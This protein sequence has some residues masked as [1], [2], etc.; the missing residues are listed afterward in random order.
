M[1]FFHVVS[2]V[3]KF[4]ICSWNIRTQISSTNSCV[5]VL[6][7]KWDPLFLSKQTLVDILVPPWGLLPLEQEVKGTVHL[8]MK[9]C[10]DFTHPYVIPNLFWSAKEDILKNKKCVFV[11]KMK[12]NGVQYCLEYNIV[13]TNFLYVLQKFG[14]TWGWIKDR[15][16]IF[17]WTLGPRLQN[18]GQVFTY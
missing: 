4:L 6:S 18:V 2:V 12:V 10:H 8:K 3:R 11:H 13:H 15:I 17:G 14:N 16:L 7:D 9:H 1:I 5:Q